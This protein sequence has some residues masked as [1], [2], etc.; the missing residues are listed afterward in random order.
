[1]TII[2]HTPSGVQV[3]ALFTESLYVGD[4]GLP[5]TSL[6]AGA[7]DLYRKEQNPSSPLEGYFS[8]GIFTTGLPD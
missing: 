6:K 7:E 2:S 3:T 5:G 4:Y 1:M 8:E